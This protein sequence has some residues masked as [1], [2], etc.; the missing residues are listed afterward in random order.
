MSNEKLDSELKHHEV[1]LMYNNPIFI[2]EMSIPLPISTEKKRFDELEP[3]CQPGRE[4]QLRPMVY[5]DIYEHDLKMQ[6]EFW[7][8]SEVNWSSDLKEF[9]SVLS[10]YEQNMVL[11]VLSFFATSDNQV[12]ENLEHQMERITQPEIKNAWATQAFFEGIHVDVYSKAVEEL[13]RD[14]VKRKS[15]KEAFQNPVTARKFAWVQKCV[16]HPNT[17]IGFRLLCFYFTEWIL[18]T[19]SFLVIYWIRD[20]H[21]IMK[22]GLTFANEKIQKDEFLHVVLSGL[23]YNH[24]EQRLTNEEV[25]ALLKDC[26][27]VEHQ[28]IDDI[29]P[30][31]TKKLSAETLKQYV[32]YQADRCLEFINYPKL[33][34]AE[35]PFPWTKQNKA[36]KTDFFTK[37]VA[38]YQVASLSILDDL[39]CEKED[40]DF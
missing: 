20:T 13:V 12:M 37:N 5:Y 23:I 26:V 10:P 24:I 40:I 18:F 34:Y 8:A 22:N 31:P 1:K 29:L 28:F 32:C 27:R 25:H 3:I 16:D 38:E 4:N 33:Y 2:E 17:F 36:N 19:S 39:V 11:Q 7:K 35:N 14:P 15:I 21:K 30:T 6:N 9:E